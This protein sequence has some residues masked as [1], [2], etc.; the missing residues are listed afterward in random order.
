MENKQLLIRFSLSGA[1]GA[2][3]FWLILEPWSNEYGFIRD[4]LILLFVALGIT[5]GLTTEKYILSARLDGIWS[6]LKQKLIYIVLIAATLAIKLLFSMTS[7]TIEPDTTIE[8]RILL[9]DI[10]G[11]MERKPWLSFSKK[12]IDELKESVGQYLD[13]MEKS[14]SN[15]NI[16]C[17]VFSHITSLLHPPT[18]D[19][20]AIGA[21]LASIRAGGGTKMLNSLKLSTEEFKK[22][23]NPYLNEIILVSDGIPENP[24]GVMN[25]VKQLDSVKIHTIGVGKTYSRQLLEYIAYETG[26]QFFP[27][28]NVSNL[29][30]VFK[31]L[32]GLTRKSSLPWWKLMLGWSL[33]GVV[34]SWLIAFVNDCGLRETIQALMPG[35]LIGGIL[36]SLFFI[37]ATSLSEGSNAGFRGMSF[38]ILG[39]IIGI[40]IYFSL[41][42][43]SAQNPQSNIEERIGGITI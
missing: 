42:Y 22:I 19:Y 21:R 41:K 3:L 8:N 9:L 4:W 1:I 13:L 2:L 36:S 14:E 33:F 6:V 27:A 26:G 35:G 40:S 10:S 28:D 30:N 31:D 15:D 16:S 5:L 20:S 25:Y 24:N 17:I 29:A 43:Y 23:D 32:G 38:A 39:F 12:P 18:T 37:V 34:I 11:S 7:Q